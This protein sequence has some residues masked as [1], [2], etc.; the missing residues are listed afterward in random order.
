MF[1]KNAIIKG[2]ALLITCMAVYGGLAQT[3]NNKS[4]AIDLPPYIKRLT[5]F[6]ERADWSLDG[7]K[8]LF[9]EKTYG[10]AYEIEVV[11]NKI[12]PITSHFYHGGFTRAMYLANGDVLLS[13]S[14]SF[15][16]ANA[17]VNRTKKAELWILDKSYTKAP[18]RLGV[19]CYEGPAVSRKNLKIAWTVVHEQYP[20]QI[21]NGEGQIWMADIVYENGVPSLQN[22]QLILDN[23]KSRYNY[24]KIETQNFIPPFDNELT[25]Q[26]YSPQGTETIKLNIESGKVTNMSNSPG[27]WT[28]PE[29]ISPDGKF[30]LV[31]SDHH[32]KKGVQYIDIYKLQ[33]D[34]SGKLER[35]TYFNNNK[36]YKASNPVIS[37]D[38]KFMALQIPKV[39][40]PPG[41]GNGIFIYD[42]EKAKQY[43]EKDAKN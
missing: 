25:F 5:Y 31:E 13:G 26:C 2:L 41:V 39:G 15:D 12:R 27:E 43:R 14:T 17:I 16:A 33:L 42:L 23:P 11:T 19:K 6:G 24:T 20:D 7:K 10:D 34:G 38:G 22:K 21:T 8:I 4:S 29:G 37:D 3:T 30:T 40:E 36:I 35:L 1:I 32:L 18:T 9:I 28:E